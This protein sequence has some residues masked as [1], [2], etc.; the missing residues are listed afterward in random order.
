MLASLFWTLAGLVGAGGGLCVAALF[1]PTVATLL[2][3]ALDFLRSPL[4]TVLGAIALALFLYVAGWIGGD[5]HG[6][7]EVRADWRADIAARVKAEALREAALRAEMTRT[8]DAG[9]AV[10]V[11]FSNSIDQK[12]KAYVAKTPLRPECRATRDD[13][14]RL[15]AIQ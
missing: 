12:V 7:A 10:D 15:L 1:V 4:G 14:R 11:S 13:V 2:K 6:A 5:I 3:A 8:A 9:A